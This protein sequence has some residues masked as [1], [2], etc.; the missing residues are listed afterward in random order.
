M[1]VIKAKPLDGFKLFLQ[2]ENNESGIA[3]LSELAGRG[4]LAAWNDRSFFEDL[5]VTSE[6]AVEWANEIDIC[7]DSLYLRVTKKTPEELFP[8]LSPVHNA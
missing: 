3:D 1:K 2:F 8:R 6:G 5:R 7:G 4:V